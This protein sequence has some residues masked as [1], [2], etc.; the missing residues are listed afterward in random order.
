VVWHGA[1]LAMFE[2]GRQEALINSGLTSEQ[3][4]SFNLDFAVV[5]LSMRFQRTP[6]LGEKVLV[7]TQLEKYQGVR[8]TWKQSI[9]SVDR[10][11]QYVT[12]QVTMVVAD[13]INKKIVRRPPKEFMEMLGCS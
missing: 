3:L 10:S 4:Q 5:D 9:F 8:L 7:S 1:Y 13:P 2:A 11:Q 12:A 6:K